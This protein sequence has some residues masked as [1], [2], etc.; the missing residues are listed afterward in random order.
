VFNIAQKVDKRTAAPCVN[1]RR[2]YVQRHNEG[3]EMPMMTTKVFYQERCSDMDIMRLAGHVIKI[4]TRSDM[5][6]SGMRTL[7]ND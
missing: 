5:R 1:C 4:N 6:V 3:G 2:I 7:V